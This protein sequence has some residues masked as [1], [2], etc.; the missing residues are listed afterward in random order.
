MLC[1]FRGL[2]TSATIFRGLPQP[3]NIA[4]RVW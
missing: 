1:S 3:A 2:R 4:S